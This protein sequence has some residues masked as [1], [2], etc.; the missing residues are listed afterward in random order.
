MLIIRCAKCKSKIM[1]YN[2]VGHGSIIKC[3]FNRIE[4]KF[5]STESDLRCTCGNKIGIKKDRYY[6]MIGKSF[7]YS[8]KIN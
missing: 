3:Y 8:G 6:K 7:I 5:V 1:K 4:K 2:K